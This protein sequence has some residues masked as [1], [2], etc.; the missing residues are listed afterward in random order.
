MGIIDEKLKKDPA[1]DVTALRKKAEAAQKALLAGNHDPA[2]NKETKVTLLGKAGMLDEAEYGDVRNEVKARTEAAKLGGTPLSD[3]DIAALYKDGYNKKSAIKQLAQPLGEEKYAELVQRNARNAAASN[4]EKGDQPSGE[5]AKQAP[6]NDA[7]A[8]A[9]R[10]E[11]LKPGDAGA[12]EALKKILGARAAGALGAGELAATMQQYGV[13]GVDD[14]SG[15]ADATGFK[16]GEA[17]SVSLGAQEY[18]QT[19][20]NEAQIHNKQRMTDEI[21]QVKP[22][23]KEIPEESRAKKDLAKQAKRDERPPHDGVARSGEDMLTATDIKKARQ[24]REAKVQAASQSIY[25]DP[26]FEAGKLKQE[27]EAVEAVVFQKTKR[28]AEIDADDPYSASEIARLKS[29]IA[30]EDKKVKAL[31]EELAN[32]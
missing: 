23:L 20:G 21:K 8:D 18:L 31:K 19:G 14:G 26:V 17:T 29:E 12:V 1:A 30:R 7:V 28:L 9:L 4:K 2:V 32:L 15:G 24:K 16:V 11:G 3:A 6:P 10:A 22:A 5:G 13:K 27:I 25:E